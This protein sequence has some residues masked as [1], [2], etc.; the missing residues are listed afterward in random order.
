[1]EATQEKTVKITNK[2]FQKTLEEKVALAEA[3]RKHKEFIRL[4]PNHTSS[5]L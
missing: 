3:K 1:M 4:N 5:I 2:T